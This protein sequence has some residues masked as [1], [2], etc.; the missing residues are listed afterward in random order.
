MTSKS[1]LISSRQ[2]GRKS[3][4]PQSELGRRKSSKNSRRH[5]LAIPITQD[6]IFIGRIEDLSQKI[7]GDIS[8]P[9]RLDLCRAVAEAQSDLMRIRQ[10]RIDVLSDRNLRKFRPGRD[11]VSILKMILNRKINSIWK[12]TIDPTIPA[13]LHQDMK[14]DMHLDAIHE[15]EKL[16]EKMFNHVIPIEEGM[17]LI[18]GKLNT[19][20]RY[21]KRALSR[22]NQAL[23]TLDD[24]DL[25]KALSVPQSSKEKRQRNSNSKDHP[26]HK[27]RKIRKIS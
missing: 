22:R 27:L 25:E 5:G 11:R 12:M 26:Q 17:G 19:L 23:H 20:E 8:D 7:A 15:Y 13:H 21:E 3:R 16:Y 4:G 2:N 24:Y 1:R 10:A 9:I 18:I 6:P 14:Y